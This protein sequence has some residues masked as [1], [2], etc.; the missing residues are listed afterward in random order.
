MSSEKPTVQFA[1]GCFRSSDPQEGRVGFQEN[2]LQ[3]LPYLT[4]RNIATR[5]M[6]PGPKWSDVVWAFYLLPYIPEP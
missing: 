5:I 2:L 6:N 1:G 3:I 4:L